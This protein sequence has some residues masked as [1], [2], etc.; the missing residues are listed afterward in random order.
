MASHLGAI[1]AN[2]LNTTV[3]NNSFGDRGPIAAGL[4]SLRSGLS[5][6]WRSALVLA[7]LFGVTGGIAVAALTMADRVESSYDELLTEID[8]PD[9]VSYCFGCEDEADTDE[10]IRELTSD[11]A[12]ARATVVR[13][14]YPIMYTADGMLLG[15]FESECDT[16]PGELS[17]W[18]NSW[19][20]E[21][22]S[23]RVTTGR[24]PAPGA[25]DEIALPAITANR[26]G[27]EVGDEIFVTGVCH[28]DAPNFQP[29][30]LS[31]VGTFVGSLDI[32]PPGQAKYFELMLV[33]L[34][35]G[36]SIGVEPAFG[37]TAVWYADN[38]DVND[39]SAESRASI[40]LEFKDHAQLIK[41]RL[42]PDATALRILAALGAV[43]G[44]AVLGQLLARHLRLLAAEHTTLRAI[45]MTRRGLWYLGIGHGALIA[46]V[47]G[48]IS[49][50]VAAVVLPLIPPGAAE[51]ILVGTSNSIPLLALA[52]SVATTDAAV[53]L[54]SLTPAWLA[55]RAFVQRGV[56]G[57]ISLA[58]RLVADGRLGTTPA[59]GVR[60]ALEPAASAQPVPVRSGLGAAAIA[61]AVVAGVITFAASL[62]H[63]R[64]TPRLVGWNWDFVVGGDDVD[65]DALAEFV[66]AHP[67]V[68]RSSFG[69]AFPSNITIRT[70]PASEEVVF[71][72]A[73]GTGTDAVTPVVVTGRA[74][75]G[76]DELLLNAALAEELDV[77]VGDGVTLL[78]QD[79]FAFLHD[80]LGVDRELPDLR[81]V[82]FELV[83]IGVLPVYGGQ[84][85]IGISMTLDGKRRAFAPA[86]RDDMISLLV[87][88]DP[89]RLVQA[90]LEMGLDELAFEIVG[91]APGATATVIQSW[92]DEELAP[93]N[94]SVGAHGVYVDLVDGVDLVAFVAD[95]MESG[96]LGEDTLVIGIHP[97]GSAS[98]ITEL[99]ALDLDDVAW[100]PAGMGT[101]MALTTVAVLAHL[102]ATGA[103]ARRRDIATLRALGMVGVQ[104]RAIIAWQATVLVVVTA[105]VAL[106]VGVVAGRYA[107]SKYAEGL[108]VVAEPVTPWAR[109]AVLFTALIATGLLASVLPGR[110]ASR[111][112]PIESLRSE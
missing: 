49:A 63:L 25:A 14:I 13:E 78:A 59:W 74:P 40:F 6:S 54:L 22:A 66:A 29:R 85:D 112:R 77:E 55:A 52:L 35:F 31:V 94:A 42:R 11:P 84:F 61:T 8:A 91:A 72:F 99:V 97:D 81:E 57:R 39:L 36:A 19:Q 47:A 7:A 33:D 92:T 10:F 4:L 100:I 41:D 21:T 30:T 5:R 26:A 34:T 90:L 18:L 102:I 96:L 106:P 53:L 32:R 16:G 101:L 76:A 70:G 3:N 86:P 23:V 108:G 12:I 20:P 38:A 88:A 104:S 87:S 43:A 79:S 46:V 28:E 67:D 17:A 58:S 69:T 111:M 103:R 27:V 1:G 15:P 65:L 83:G 110:A 71:D 37:A 107:W 50:G 48:A 105:A 44:I 2:E 98:R 80:S 89:D 62:D 60:L 51:G 75:E 64:T 93:L 24:L 9:N 109:L 56:V 95:F 82:E 68:E 45:G 73:F